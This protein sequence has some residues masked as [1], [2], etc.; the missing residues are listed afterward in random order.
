MP[1]FVHESFIPAPPETVFAF[2]ERPDALAL[3]IPPFDKTQVIRP[4]AG[5]ETG[6]EVVLRTRLFPGVWQTIVARH[7]DF[8]RGEF[9]E[10]TMVRGPFRRW[11]HR[12]VFEPH[13]QGCMLRDEIEYEP[14]LGWLGRLADPLLIRPRLRRMFEFR[15][16]VTRREVLKMAGIQPDPS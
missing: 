16:E 3:L 1:R 14:P 15:H 10:D 7:T 5:L 6:T 8:R 13:G 12:H 11:R 4:P 2:H 9:F